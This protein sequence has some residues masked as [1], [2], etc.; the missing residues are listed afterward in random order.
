MNCYSCSRMALNIFIRS[1]TGAESCLS[2]RSI[3]FRKPQGPRF[4]SRSQRLRE[5]GQFPAGD[6]Q[7]S[8]PSTETELAPNQSQ[9]RKN[10]NSIS[11]A[12]LSSP[13][14]IE[15]N[16]KKSLERWQV[17]KAALKEKFGNEGWNPRKKLSPDAMEGIRHLHKTHPDKFTT[18]VLAQHFKV[19]PEAI[20]RIL[21]SKWQPTDEEQEE[22]LR[23]WD[24]RGERIWSNLVELGIKPPKKWREMGVGKAKHGEVPNWKSGR[25]NSVAVNDSVGEEII[26]IVDK[27]S[28][29]AGQSKWQ[30]MPMSERM[31]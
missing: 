11:K 16:P 10:E 27:A 18:P 23:R 13:K 1:F 7:S 12:E 17:Q 26:P 4:F 24:K 29:E 19:S 25:R 20:R 6:F 8:E 22:R 2:T 15:A 31:F 21:K 14:P 5:A 30:R 28:Q 3:L 9:K